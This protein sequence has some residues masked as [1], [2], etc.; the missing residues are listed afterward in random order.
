[1]SHETKW[2]TDEEEGI[3]ESRIELDTRLKSLESL[4]GMITDNNE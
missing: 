1:M 3:E 2:G 4:L